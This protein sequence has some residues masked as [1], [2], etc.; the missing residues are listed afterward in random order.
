MTTRDAI[1]DLPST[2]KGQK[3][4]AKEPLSWLQRLTRWCP[5]KQSFITQI[6]HHEEK[7]INREI[8]MARIACIPKTIGADW[9]D[10]PNKDIELPSGRKAI[11]LKYPYIGKSNS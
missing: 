1:S 4:L 3:V 8:V 5:K 7:V 6:S 9:R 11:K 2:N 10:L